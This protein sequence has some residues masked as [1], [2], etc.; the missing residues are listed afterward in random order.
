MLSSSD[1]IT[2]LIHYMHVR[3][4]TVGEG[5]GEENTSFK[6]NYIRVGLAHNNVYTR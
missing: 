2:G 6:G 1:L 3:G 5:G 4:E